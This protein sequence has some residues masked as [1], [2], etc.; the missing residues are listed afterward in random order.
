MPA[1]ASDS[2]GRAATPRRRGRRV[3]LA[4]VSATLTVCAAE[5]GHRLWQS[6][7]GRPFDAAATLA[8]LRSTARV[9]PAGDAR[10]SDELVVTL[11]PYFGGETEHDVSRV[12]ERF[13][14]EPESESLRVLVFGGSV[15]H[16][17]ARDVAELASERLAAVPALAGRRVEIFDCAHDAYKQPQQL[18]KL[19]YLLARGFRPD[20]VIELDGFNELA[21]A[22]WNWVER[23]D[24]LFPT[25]GLWSIATQ[26]ASFSAADYERIGAA[27]S[28]RRDARALAERAES[29]GLHHSSIVSRWLLARIRAQN[30]RID[31]LERAQ[32][33]PEALAPGS[34]RWYQIHGHEVP[35]DNDAAM[36]LCL[37]AW[38]ECSVSM[39]A[40]CEARGIA[41][42]HVLQPTLY[43]LGSKPLS[44]GEQAT[45]DEFHFWRPPVRRH[46]ATLRERG[47]RLRARGVEFL[48][49]S[50]VF[51]GVERELYYDQCHFVVEGN[52]LLWSFIEPKVVELLARA[53]R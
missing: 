47:A 7:R 38:E 20:L 11:H 49:A 1:P 34:S 8:E 36:E 41:Y 23:T 17:L 2:S 26:S 6:S 45:A 51:A 9:A 43:D 31:A 18:N 46:Y 13:T 5:F 33:N 15:A 16:F 29:W 40:L 25:F 3:L 27:W 10:A 37:R 12:V 44:P 4:L 52:V 30:E 53:R 24:P 42:L 19:T 21:L 14:R 32:S 39:A 50:H 48:D 35:A 22:R 28:L